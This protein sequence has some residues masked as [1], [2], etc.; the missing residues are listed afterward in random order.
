MSLYLLQHLRGVVIAVLFAVFAAGILITS[1]SVAQSPPQSPDAVTV[2]RADGTVTASWD[3]VSGAT[4]YHA[5][6]S[7]DDRGSWHGPVDDHT[8]IQT[9]SITFNADNAKNIIVGIRAGNDNGWSA[10]T[11][12]PTVGPYTPTPPG[13][14]SSV[15][16]TRADG[17]VTAS[18]DAVSGATKY[19][20]MYSDDDRGSWHGPVDDHT[21]IQTT[22]IT[23][24]ADNDKSIIVGVRAGNEHGWSDWTD[25]PTA[26]TYPPTPPG[27][28]SSVSVT[29]ADGTVTASWQ[30]VPGAT[31][32]HSM[33]S[34]DDRGSWHGPVDDH[35]NI[36]TT[37]ITFNADNAKSV[38]V[39]V[40]AG[41]DQGW[42]VWTDSPSV[43]PYAPPTITVDNIT[44]SSANITIAN[45]TKTWWYKTS[46]A[47][48]CKGP[49][50]NSATTATDLDAESQ[51]TITAYSQAGCSQV[52][53]TSGSFNTQ[54]AQQGNAISV[55]KIRKS[56]ATITRSGFTGD[57]YYKADKEPHTQ[58]SSAVTT[59]S[60][61]L[62]GL[63]SVTTYS[64][65]AY[66]DATCATELASTS[67]TT[68]GKA[69]P[70]VQQNA[71]EISIN[72]AALNASTWSYRIKLASDADFQ[73]C[74][75]L[76][77]DTPTISGLKADA[78]A[79]I[80]VFRH[81]ACESAELYGEMADLHGAIAIR[82][83][84]ASMSV[85]INSTSPTITISKWI[86]QKWYYRQ[87]SPVEGSCS[88]EVAA[89]TYGADL[90]NLI[91][92]TEYRYDAYE[93]SSCNDSISDATV[94]F[95][96]AEFIGAPGTTTAVLQLNHWD[97][98]WW[99]RY[100]GVY[101]SS[102]ELV[103]WSHGPCRGPQTENVV[104]VTGL[105]SG[106]TLGFMAYA[107]ETA[108]RDATEP[109]D[110]S[111]NDV[112]G[113]PVKVKTGAATL[114]ANTLPNGKVRLSIGN[115]A[116][117]EP[118]WYYRINVITPPTSIKFH[119]PDGCQGPVTNGATQVDADLPTI[120]GDSYHIFTVYPASG[121]NGST[122]AAAARLSGPQIQA[123]LTAT[124]IQDTTGSLNIA[125][126]PGTW[127]YRTGPA[128]H[129]TCQGPVFTASEVL[130]AL[131]AAES[132]LYVAYSD[133]AC[134][135][136]IAIANHFTTKKLTVSN[137]TDNSAKL[138]IARYTGSWYAKQTAPSAGNCSSA[139]NAS[140]HDITSLNAGTSYTFK[141]YSDSGCSTVLATV[142]FTTL[143]TLE[144]SNETATTATIEIKDHT[145]NWY[146]KRTTPTDATCKAITT[147]SHNLDNLAHNTSFTFKAYSDSAC[148][149]EL[150]PAITFSTTNPSLAVSNRR[151][152]IATLTLS[153]WNLAIDGA[154]YYNYTSPS[155]GT[156]STATASSHSLNTLT[157]NTDYTFKAY[158]DSGCNNEIAA[159]PN[160]FHDDFNVSS[161]HRPN[162]ESVPP[163]GLWSDGTTLYVTWRVFSQGIG[164]VVAYDLATLARQKGKDSPEFAI[165]WVPEAI[166]GNATT[167]WLSGIHS[168]QLAAYHRNTMQRD[169]SKDI[170][171]G[172]NSDWPE[173]IWSDG[174][175]IWVVEDDHD[176][177]FAFR[178]SD[179]TR[180]ASKDF[181]TLSAAGNNSPFGLWS[182]GETMWVVDNSD[183][184]LYAYK[185]S[186]KSR[187][188]SRDLD[189]DT[190]NA[191]PRG[192]WF[193]SNGVFVADG[194]DR[195]VYYYD[196]TIVYLTASN[197]AANTATLSIDKS[198]VTW[199]YK[200]NKAPDN[201]CSQMQTGTTVELAGLLA[202]TSYSYTAYS[203]SSC[204]K[205]LDSVDF[206]TTSPSVTLSA[207]G[208]SH[209]A[210][211]LSIGTRGVNWHYKA[212]QSPHTTCSSIVTG[213]GT[214][215]AG[216]TSGQAYTYTAYTDSTCSTTLATATFET[217]TA[218]P[219]AR[220]PAKDFTTLAQAGVNPRGIW[221][222]GT[223][224]W[225]QSW[226]GTK[227]H[228]FDMTTKAR[229]SSKDIT[230]D[231]S[232]SHANGITG[233]GTTVWVSNYVTTDKIFAHSISSKSYD[234]GKN[235]TLHADNDWATYLWTDGTT[236]WV[237]DQGDKKI[238]AYT[239]SNGSRDTS[240]EI[241]LHADN[242]Y[243][244][245]IWGDGT[246]MWV[247]DAGTNDKLFA[248]KISDGTRDP[249]K[250]YNGL[251]DSSLPENE[252]IEEL[253]GIWSDGTTMWIVE[254]RAGEQKIYAFTH[255]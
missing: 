180:D 124:N 126:Y 209:N 88:P 47:G 240:K 27:A 227:I 187:D 92:G 165:P 93:D 114:T 76:D 4:K 182:D 233:D 159:G 134:T 249:S 24:S 109:L 51:Y 238:Y 39:G 186:D 60:V 21:N 49:V 195:K 68:T 84:K 176:K 225:V 145:G 90:S 83:P 162:T 128:P 190:E 204:T 5:M 71:N 148:S 13:A 175:T 98:P 170:S 125:N 141:A 106:Y 102:D 32:Y 200:S 97:K 11:D 122:V 228:A 53:V 221:S 112:L 247:A 113:V 62:T 198:G 19:H 23:F 43:G 194:E 74:V 181:N 144:S 18:W 17:T 213:P 14:V 189:L 168:G 216:L 81:R 183:L 37:S 121:C 177:I 163:Y 140:T 131:T 229:D 205:T 7:D 169:S 101:D 48:F 57:W 26:G 89:G 185:M 232:I 67:F 77:A 63:G 231:S 91:P 34:D 214:S 12:S 99:Y 118:D 203:D 215:L 132:Y 107:N 167:L 155:G 80:E 16:V 158:S 61:N 217:K 72:T 42:G 220:H 197:I 59:D 160:S 45:W 156:C 6:Y 151:Y 230:L 154:W 64:Y 188:A 255:P 142:S 248:Y 150:T 164:R 25:S 78:T 243:P 120:S 236:M 174:Q 157:L 138:K 234:S 31:K 171:L 178:L 96:I 201:T 100:I 241:T 2:T 52:I 115:W 130:T 191:D 149:A 105:D 1:D 66:S 56:S 210:A 135:V 133:S 254:K 219:G 123:S 65:S 3:A 85:N 10:W 36:Q 179:G 226:Q 70:I 146:L 211:N 111:L 86:N 29:R 196:Y 50:F 202:N 166:W 33:Y 110:L 199:Y 173:E 95:T 35:T 46:S 82:T 41:N 218:G 55:T 206:T 192:I 137:I 108:C 237:L 208:I 161:G 75:Y 172:S 136:E 127:Y 207:F 129:D 250:D 54:P 153:D 30:A 239:I 58:C 73:G 245:G 184:K 119:G 9:T 8:N 223:T 212:D 22:S 252:K 152:S 104:T 235:I 15:S 244:N 69:I 246:T 28:V 116:K 251:S 94:T 147:K 143:A 44:S 103:E 117:S 222:D 87:E 224:M 253:A 40:R 193:T 20:A 79:S 242:Q 38:I 139:I